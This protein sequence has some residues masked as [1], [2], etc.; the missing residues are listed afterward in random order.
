MRYVQIS[1]LRTYYTAV[2]FVVVAGKN[3]TR[4]INERENRPNPSAKQVDSQFGTP[5]GIAVWDIYF[6]A[7]GRMFSSPI[8]H[9]E[10]HV[11]RPT[12]GNPRPCRCISAYIAA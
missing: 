7:H 11:A 3:P 5:R 9:I 8:L 4:C 2:S 1:H 6:H 12:Q 10:R